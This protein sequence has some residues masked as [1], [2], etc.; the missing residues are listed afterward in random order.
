M[1]KK[2]NLSFVIW[3][4]FLLEVAIRTGMGNVGPVE[5]SSNPEKIS[6]ACSFSDPED[7]DSL[8]EV[9]LIRVG[10]KLCRTAAFPIPALEY[11]D[12]VVIKGWTCSA[13]IQGV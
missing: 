12:S 1:I 6:S 7:I 9:C 2:P 4:V 3:H 13:T 5:F 11:E 10:T 8:V